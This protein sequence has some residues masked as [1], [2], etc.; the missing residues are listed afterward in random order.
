MIFKK[1]EHNTDLKKLPQGIDALDYLNFNSKP[2]ILMDYNYGEDAIKVFKLN[3]K[4]KK[5]FGFSDDFYVVYIG[6]EG[7]TGYDVD[8]QRVLETLSSIKPETI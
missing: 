6:F 2:I 1:I 4:E 5:Y 8:Y 3:E 7:E